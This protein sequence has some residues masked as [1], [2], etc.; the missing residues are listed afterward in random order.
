LN[1]MKIVVTGGTGVVG[2]RIVGILAAQGHQVTS[3]SQRTGVDVITG[4][5]LDEALVGSEVVVDVVNSPAFDDATALRFFETSSRNILTS[6]AATG[7]RHYVALSIVGSERL[8]QNGYFRAKLLQE[9]LVK[10]GGVPF[11]IVRSTQFF[12][13][14]DAV[15]DAAA[16]GEE[17][18]LSPARVQFVAAQDVASAL[19]DIAVRA[20]TNE[21]LE[22]AGPDPFRLDD[23]A[24]RYL[25]ARGDSRRVVADPQA[26]YFGTVLN[27]ETLIAGAVPRF[28][29]TEFDSWLRQQAVVAR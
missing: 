9:R 10:D 17:V 5:G 11:T 8:S 21:T 26:L 7:V 22:V 27:D 24:R 23:L 12:E 20:P 6:A 16:D 3:A 25:A 28:G 19:A 4:Q 15:V 29:H 18:R 13:F 14:L 1:I 2:S